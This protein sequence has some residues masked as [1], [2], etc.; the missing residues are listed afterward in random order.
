MQP[1]EKEQKVYDVFQ[2]ISPSYDTMN[3]IISFRLHKWW[4]KA[5][6]RRMQV[7]PGAKCLDVCC[8]T[9]DW[10]IQLAEAAGNTGV[11]KGLDFSENM[12]AVGQAKVA[13][14]PTIEL[15]HGNAMALPFGDHSFDYVTIGFGLR[16]VPDY[17]T[18]LREL[19][20][21]LKPGG[22][23]VCLETSQPT[24]PLF[25]ELYRFYFGSVMPLFGKVFAGSYDQYKW[26]QESTDQFPDRLTLKRMFETAG[27]EQVEVKAF[28]G[29]AC[30]M[31]L[32]K[33]W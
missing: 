8:G 5:T 16:N 27:F 2:S 21:V 15:I 7:F 22:T 29:G 26:L 17:M 23:V 28:S 20:R 33:K 4:R 1:K 24:A 10:T 3:S 31:H 11:V 18:V 14:Y 9:A 6:M 30:A 12:L 25:S 32:G 13:D 19:H